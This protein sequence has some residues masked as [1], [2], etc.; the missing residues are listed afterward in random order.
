[1]ALSDAGYGETREFDREHT[2]VI[3]GVTG[4]QELVISLGSRLGHPVV[5]SKALENKGLN[6]QQKNFHH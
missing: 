5:A 4:T 3:L 6:D 2:S 1:M